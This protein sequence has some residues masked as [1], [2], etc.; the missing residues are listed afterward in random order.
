MIIFSNVRFE[1]LKGPI[2]ALSHAFYLF[3]VPLFSTSNMVVSGENMKCL[4]SSKWLVEIEQNKQ[5]SW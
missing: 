3:F 1:K 2:A 5:K 4:L